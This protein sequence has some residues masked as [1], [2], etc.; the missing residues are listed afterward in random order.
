VIDLTE[1]I[2]D[3]AMRLIARGLAANRLKTVASGLENIPA[4]GPVLI[5]V[6]H[7]HHLY[8]GLAL[9]AVLPRPFHI[10]V[11]MDW[12]QT[13]PTKIFMESINR[14]ARW[15]MV[16]RG[17][18]LLLGNN[19]KQSLFS[20]WDAMRYKR[21]AMRQCVDLLVQGRLLVVFAEGYPNID[22]V[23]TP[24]TEP[25][26]FLPFKAGFVNIAS[27]AER[28]LRGKVP[29][30]PA[31]LRY[32]EGKPWI[33]HIAFGEAIYRDEFSTKLELIMLLERKV[34]DLSGITCDKKS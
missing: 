20:E 23:H 10:V 21:A 19:D 16:L 30:I 1:T 18:A 7:Y 32:N 13:K 24:K 26:E 6:R 34:K 4:H 11:T 8:D 27:A 17:D 3:K 25:D 33:G 14:W 28:R 22:P 12:V 2:I 9:F 5:V 15:P 31:G 29:I